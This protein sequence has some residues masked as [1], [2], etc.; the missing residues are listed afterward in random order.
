M[1]ERKVLTKYYPP[2]FDPSLVGR[3]RK[4]KTQGPKVQTVRLMAP[5]SLRCVSCGEYMYRGRKFN[6]RKETPPGEKYLGIQLYRFYI[7]CTRCSAEIV[8]RTDP[9][10][11]DYVVERGAKRNTD[12]W[13][14]GLDGGQEEEETVE[15][16][17]DRLE[18]EM[19]EAEGE[20]ERNAMAELEAKTEDAKREMAVAD[21]L[22]EI[23]NRNARL[24]RAQREGGADVLE[25]VVAGVLRPEEEER[26][27]QEEEDAEA[28]RRAF[29]FA[30]RQEVLEEVV[31]EEEDEGGN[32][33]PGSGS[34]SGSASAGASTSGSHPASA[35][36][37][38][39]VAQP[40]P[41]PSFKRQV[42]KKKDH[43]A[44]LGIKKKQPLV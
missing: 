18:R 26:R 43:A 3:A 40:P 44:L 24:E 32:A 8:F 33:G 30:R 21:A 38:P 19:A 34:G 9:K 41:P 5:F 35:I 14:R 7:R 17:L 22:D 13:K 16:R 4:P 42:K 29:A 6:A 23:R 15:Q 1:S 36:A 20:E 25:A 27:R 28:A 39:D 31:E 12:P 37:T 10:N 11:Q 2:D